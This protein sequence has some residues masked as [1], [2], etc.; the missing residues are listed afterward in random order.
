M[1]R[2]RLNSRPLLTLVT[3][4]IGTLMVLLNARARQMRHEQAKPLGCL[5]AQQ[6]LN[7]SGPISQAVAAQSGPLSLTAETAHC[8]GNFWEVDCSD[9][10]GREL[11]DLTWNADTGQ[12]SE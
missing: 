3:L 9:A 4:L 8:Q 7:L 5:T 12:L 10:L 11:M 2:N 6:V 1:K